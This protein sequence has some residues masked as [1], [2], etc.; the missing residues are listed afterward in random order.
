MVDLRLS[1]KEVAEVE[2]TEHSYFD[3]K[4]GEKVEYKLIE[5]PDAEDEDVVHIY[6]SDD[7]KIKLN[8]TSC[9]LKPGCL[10]NI[11]ALEDVNGR[12]YLGGENT[13]AK[14]IIILDFKD[15][16]KLTRKIRDGEKIYIKKKLS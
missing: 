9:K 15:T 6:P 4:K 2:G 10:F 11:E 1:D 12:I 5:E 13:E 8:E 14:E 3:L 7:K 16:N